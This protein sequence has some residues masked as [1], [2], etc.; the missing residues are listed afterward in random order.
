VWANKAVSDKSNH[1]IA[2][3]RLANTGLS[4][5]L[6]YELY[7]LIAPETATWGET[8]P[9][10]S[11]Q[12]TR[13]L[14]PGQFRTATVGIQYRANPWSPLYRSWG[15]W[16]EVTPGQA[17][18]QTFTTTNAPIPGEWYYMA[19]EADYTTNQYIGFWLSGPGI[20]L[21]V[22]LSG[23]RIAQEAKFQEEAFWL[24]LESENIYNNCGTAGN[25]AY[26]VYYD[27][28]ALH[29]L[30]ENGTVLA[31]GNSSAATTVSPARRGTS[32]QQLFLPLIR[33]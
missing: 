3:K 32:P 4:G 27:A 25:F 20:E 14:A 26:G 9:E 24:T 15:V 7:A 6:R 2:Q 12:N 23:Y 8:G 17:N 28:V 1:V 33:H 22:D 13:E 16:A 18:W 19:V 21:A 11:L 31:A 5:R 29:Q 30:D 10:F